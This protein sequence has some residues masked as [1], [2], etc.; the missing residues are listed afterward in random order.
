VP[1]E[2]FMHQK[3]RDKLKLNRKENKGVAKYA[4]V[5]NNIKVNLCYLCEAL[6]FFA[7]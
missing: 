1:D 3:T 4:K 6:A 5:Q 7:V 2:Y